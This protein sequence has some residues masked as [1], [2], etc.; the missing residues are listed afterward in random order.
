MLLA[1]T[2]KMIMIF[3]FVA[4]AKYLLKKSARTTF[5]LSKSC[6]VIWDLHLLGIGITAT[7]LRKA[8]GEKEK[9]L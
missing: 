2:G 9:V 5:Q 8:G 6:I 7:S 4:N 3:F 1:N